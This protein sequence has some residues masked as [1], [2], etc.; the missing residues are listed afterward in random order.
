[1]DWGTHRLLMEQIKAVERD[2]EYYN[3]RI[4]FY[5]NEEKCNECNI[6]IEYLKGKLEGLRIAKVIINC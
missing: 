5:E 4:V 3:K 6:K 1:M 2:I